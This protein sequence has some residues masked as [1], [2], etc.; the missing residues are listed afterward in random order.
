MPQQATTL[1]ELAR[2][3]ADNRRLL[4][5][6]VGTQG[7]AL[8]RKNFDIDDN[9]SGDSEESRFGAGVR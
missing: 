8:G 3:R 5:V 7:T 9:P 2:I 1:K 4:N 6:I